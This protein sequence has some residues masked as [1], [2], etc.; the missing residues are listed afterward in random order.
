MTTIQELRVIVEDIKTKSI[1][2]SVA[3]QNLIVFVREVEYIIAETNPLS[4]AVNIDAL[5]AIYSPIYLQ[6][7]T[8]IET[9]ADALGTDVL[10]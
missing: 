9:A 7:L 6:K 10:H 4:D 8:R 1:E 2:M 5:I 3:S